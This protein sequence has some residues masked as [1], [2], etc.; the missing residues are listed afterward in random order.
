MKR[1]SD[2]EFEKP[3]LSVSE[4]RGQPIGEIRER[5]A[6]E[7]TRCGFVQR[8]VGRRVAPERKTCWSA[9]LDRDGHMMGTFS[10]TV[11]VENRLEIWNVRPSPSRA[12]L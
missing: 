10:R 6:V 4:H 9:S 8:L 3:S 11:K 12:R 2:C 7:D 5:Y 1:E